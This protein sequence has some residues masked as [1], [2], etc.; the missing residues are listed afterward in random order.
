[1]DET[2]LL[3]RATWLRVRGRILSQNVRDADIFGDET[4]STWL[5]RRYA[6]CPGADGRVKKRHNVI[7]NENDY[8][9]VALAA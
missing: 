6:A 1:M 4:G 8:S 5:R 3:D 7:A 9:Q 2:A